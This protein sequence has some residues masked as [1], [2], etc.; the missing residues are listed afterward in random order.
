M[1][2]SAL[3]SFRP[4]RRAGT[5]TVRPEYREWLESAGLQTAAD[6]LSLSGVVVSGHVGRNVSRVEIAGKS[7]YLKREHAVR[8]RDRFRSWRAG[9]GWASMSA[10]EAA[11]LRRL[12]ERGLPVPTWLAY[13]E[14]ER[15]A[16]L[17]VAA[18]EDADDL[19]SAPPLGLSR[20]DGIGRVIARIH[21]AGVDQPDLFAKHFLL[22]RRSIA[23]TILDW[24]RAVI[25]KVVPWP[26]RIRGLAALR[27]T[28]GD[29]VSS[30]SVWIDL[31]RAYRDE[32]VRHGVE[33][34]EAETLAASV[35]IHARSLARRPGLRSQR[36][37]AVSQELVRI[38]GET[39]CAIPGVAG[40]LAGPDGIARVYDPANNGK[41]IEVAGRT[42]VLHVRRTRLPFGRW[43]AAVRGRA[44]RS[45]ELR[46]ARLLFH[47][48][49]YGIPAPKLLA[50]GQRVPRFG[51]AGSFVLFEPQSARPIH[52][53]DRDPVL[54]LLNR[55]H[56]IGLR[57]S[58]VGPEGQPFGMT[59]RGPVIQ[60]VRHLRLSRRITGSQVRR[61]WARLDAFFQRAR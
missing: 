21:Q 11:V 56:T 5:C 42:G 26:R 58:G 60:D 25:R 6:I 40:D 45:P 9:F 2:A 37:P 10:R 57:L 47:L 19:R 49:R 55:L 61:D 14:A 12:D 44:W 51:R 24:Q 27:T 35:E 17:L 54:E 8:L 41:Q 28:A 38:E 1:P 31:L 15:S 4:A 46:V 39:V 48:E 18:V 36:L 30:P 3:R 59:D 53:I 52:P 34:P 7:A 33:A 32:V 22:Q 29:E 43:W 13:G 50:Y 20:A 23:L 16:F